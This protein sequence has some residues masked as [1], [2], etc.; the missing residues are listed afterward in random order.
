MSAPSTAPKIEEEER[1]KRERE[2][3]RVSE[4]ASRG[5]KLPKTA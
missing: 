3:E 1:K 4:Q 2:R 5:E